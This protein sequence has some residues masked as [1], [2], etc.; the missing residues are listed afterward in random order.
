MRENND[1]YNKEL[2]QR[3]ADL[4]I[5]LHKTYTDCAD[6]KGMFSKSLTSIVPTKRET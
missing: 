2:E 4:D 5:L 1:K 3:R 6:V